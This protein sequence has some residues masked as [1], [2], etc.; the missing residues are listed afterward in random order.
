VDKSRRKFIVGTAVASAGAVVAASAQHAHHEM[1]G[2]GGEPPRSQDTGRGNAA[3]TRVE[4]KRRREKAP[5]RPIVPVE[6]PDVPK[7][8]YTMDGDVKVF[9][10]RAEPVVREFLPGKKI[11]VWGFNGS[12]P[13]PTVEITEGDRVRFVVDNGLPEEFSM[14]W[15]GLEVPQEMDGV[16]GISQDPIQPGGSFTYEFTVNQNG[17]Y[18]YHSHMAMQEMMGM[19][20]AFVVQPKE[21]YDPPVDRD[22]VVFWQEW[23]ILPNNPTPN[24]MAMEFNWLTMNGK[25]GPAATPMLA[26]QGERIRIRNINLGMDHHPIHL[27]NAQFVV[28][29]TEAGRKPQSTW[30]RENTVLL[31][32]AQARDIEFTGDRA[33]DHM[34]HCHLP[35]H[36]MNGMASMVGPVMGIGHGIEPGTEESGMGIVTGGHAL[37]S[38]YGPK[39]GRTL[40]VG[41]GGE[42]Q[43]TNL[44]VTSEGHELAQSDDAAKTAAGGHDQMPGMQMDHSKHA[45]MAGMQHGQSGEMAN[46]PGMQHGARGDAT[47][48]PGYPQDMAMVMDDMVAKPE[49]YGLRKGW[50][51][52]MMG[53]MT[54]V[55]VLTPEMYDEIER[56][57]QNTTPPKQNQQMPEHHHHPGMKMP[58]GR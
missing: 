11:N 4:G 27:H 24:T 17:T 5:S 43:T 47:S 49:T 22:F 45:G 38:E 57:K 37:S 32:V 40:A 3:D 13:G 29:G 1:G 12:M 53:M 9:R 58:G 55:R 33:I 42:T 51:M 14:H 46:M 39:L 21:A 2:M 20:G 48:V 7:A 52:G 41:A 10:L 25:T 50:T 36:M 15:H 8:E 6:S 28:T 23:A 30:F 35:H 34:L 18:F 19:I 54:L 31:G 26:K 56:Q 16:P 44:P